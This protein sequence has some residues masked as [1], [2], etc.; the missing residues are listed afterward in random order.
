MTGNQ[1]RRVDVV[2]LMAGILAG[3]FPAE[4]QTRA[5]LRP[6]PDDVRL[7]RSRR[8][9]MLDF[10]AVPAGRTLAPAS[11]AGAKVEPPDV[12]RVYAPRLGI[13]DP[14]VELVADGQQVDRLRWTRSTFRQVHRG[15]PVYSGMLYVHQ[16]ATGAVRAINGRFYPIK[17][18]LDVTPTLSREEATAVARRELGEPAVETERIDLVIVDPGWYGDPSTGP[19][20]AYHIV[21]RSAAG[22]IRE[23]F[24]I[25][26]H[27]GEILDR[28]SMVCTLLQRQV[29]DILGGSDCCTVHDLP[30]CDDEACEQ[31]VCDFE[32]TCCASQWHDFCQI[33]AFNF[34]FDL[35]VPG[36]L[37]RGEGDPPTGDPDI[38][39]V[40]D[41]FGDTYDFFRRAFGRDGL[42][43]AGLLVSATVN[44]PFFCPNAFWDS[45]LV[46]AGFCAGTAAD[47]IVAHELTHG[48]TEYTADLIYQNQPGQLNESFSDVFGELVDL[49][50]GDA[51]EADRIG[52]P[53][54]PTHPT[55]GGTD[56]PNRRRTRCSRRFSRFTDGVR[57]LIGE[58][59]LVFRV[60]IRDMWDPTCEEDPDRANSPLQTCDVVDAG[61]VHSGSGVPNHAFALLTDGGAFNGYEIPAIGAVKAA[62]VWYR[63]LTT[64]LTL[65]SDFEDAFMAFNQAASDLVGTFPLHP[66]TGKPI[67]EMFTEADAEAVD[68]ALRSV[69]MNSIGRCGH[70]SPVLSSDPPPICA[71]RTIVFADDFENGPGEWTV[72]NTGPTTPY[73]W[74]QVGDLPFDRPG[75]AW[76]V[77]NGAALA[78]DEEVDESAV[79]SLISPPIALP[80]EEGVPYIAFT[81]YVQVEPAYDGGVLRV[82]VNG[83]TWQDVERERF[84][85]N[86]YNGELRDVDFYRNTNPLAGR[87]A[88][89]GVGGR[90]GTTIVRLNGLAGPGDT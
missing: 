28:W 19:H 4:G 18:P 8:T 13:R 2:F 10:L 57:W 47:D 62:A 51:E 64:Y 49:F 42:D 17:Q 74:A 81:H 87:A 63:A 58:D 76:F 67:D 6:L 52:P 88:W 71:H 44:W 41:Y 77:D 59:A 85:F 22:P 32:E 43:G 40:Y 46:L 50:N 35:C 12:L 14:D 34:C 26:A 60:P 23:A 84:E 15:I 9:G 29:Y 20:L 89:T 70:N 24:F 30:R 61:G 54:W 73:D 45:S 80:P 37:V 78:C 56:H 1:R 86:G 27:S 55:G 11:L 83:G 82:R 53:L 72:E 33:I 66:A 7:H 75:T 38:D 48:L 16:D 39:A 79:H 5:A 3:S 31:Q 25:D 68:L 36:G 69:E 21:L 90:W 65:A